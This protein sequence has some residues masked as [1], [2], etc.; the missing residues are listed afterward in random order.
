MHYCILTYIKI[1]LPPFYLPI[2]FKLSPFDRF[3]HHQH[4]WL[5]ER[6]NITNKIGDVTVHYLFQVTDEGTE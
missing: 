3:S 4:I 6:G 1:I 2:L 5:L